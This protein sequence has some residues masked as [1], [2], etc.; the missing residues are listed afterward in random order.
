MES[1]ELSN[2][3]MDLKM[4]IVSNLQIYLAT[5]LSLTNFTMYKMYHKLYNR[6]KF[7]RFFPYRNARVKKKYNTIHLI[8][9]IFI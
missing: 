6:A 2:F 7:I 3:L 5:I 8:T 9:F 4:T 1:L